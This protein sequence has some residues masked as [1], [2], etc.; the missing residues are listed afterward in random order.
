MY[1][2]SF[3]KEIKMQK[4]HAQDNLVD[5]IH[6]SLRYYIKETSIREFEKI[7]LSGG[8]SRINGLA[9]YIGEKVNIPVEL[10]NPIENFDLPQVFNPQHAPQIAIAC[11]LALREE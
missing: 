1:R 9:G 8:S 6:R 11:G 4:K 5:E 10:F 3:R 7:L 2:R